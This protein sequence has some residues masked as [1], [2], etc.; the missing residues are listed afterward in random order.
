MIEFSSRD[1]DKISSNI[2]LRCDRRN[3][4]NFTV[5]ILITYFNILIFLRYLWR[6][7]TKLTNHCFFSLPFQSNLVNTCLYLIDPV[8]CC[9]SRSSSALPRA[10]GAWK[11]ERTDSLTVK[12][13]HIFMELTFCSC[14]TW[15]E[16]KCVYIINATEKLISSIRTLYLPI[17]TLRWLDFQDCSSIELKYIRTTYHQHYHS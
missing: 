9:P 3:F 8:S 12:Q 1:T 7:N 17:L 5:I 6:S 16:H 13:Q 2:S 14:R 11:S 15:I 4:L 10:L